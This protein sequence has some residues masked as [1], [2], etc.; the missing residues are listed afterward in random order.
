[1]YTDACADDDIIV[2]NFH[3]IHCPFIIFGIKL[4]GNCFVGCGF[5]FNGGS[6][7]LQSHPLEDGSLQLPL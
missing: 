1:M 4:E 7:I 2:H 5:I 3:I 6:R